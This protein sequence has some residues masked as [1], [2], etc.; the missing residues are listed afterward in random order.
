MPRSLD[1]PGAKSMH[2]VGLIIIMA[3]GMPIIAWKKSFNNASPQAWAW[4][5]FLSLAVSIQTSIQYCSCRHAPSA[6]RGAECMAECCSP[7]ILSWWFTL[8]ACPAAPRRGAG[9]GSI[10][11]CC[12]GSAWHTGYYIISVIA[13]ELQ[14]G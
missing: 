11:W 14:I 9:A 5:D 7:F 4:R 8:P 1:W 10:T 13:V 12:T 2:S 6:V 3:Y